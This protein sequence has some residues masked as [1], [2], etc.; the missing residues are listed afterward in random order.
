ML[1]HFLLHSTRTYKLW[2]FILILSQFQ[3][4][5]MS[6]E[7]W[8]GLRVE[9]LK[10]FLMSNFRIKKEN[11]SSLS[12]SLKHEH[13]SISFVRLSMRHNDK[14]LINELREMSFCFYG[15]RSQNVTEVVVG[16]SRQKDL[17]GHIAGQEA[18]RVTSQNH[19]DCFCQ[20]PHT[21]VA[22]SWEIFK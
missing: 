11:L 10:R 22:F 7:W 6:A 14:S 16:E 5:L 2:A 12:K 13:K 19:F 8:E 21:F 3:E 17:R 20:S 9:K 18:G 1:K 4:A 15:D